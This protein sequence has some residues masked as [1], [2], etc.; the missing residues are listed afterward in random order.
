MAALRKLETEKAALEEKRKLQEAEF[1]LERLR[2][3]EALAAEK[4]AA[5]RELEE[6]KAK[7]ERELLRKQREAEEEK[8]R[9]Q[10]ELEL[11]KQRAENE[12]LRMELERLK[13]VETTP[14]SSVSLGNVSSSSKSTSSSGQTAASSSTSQSVYAAER[15]LPPPPPPQAPPQSPSR[16]RLADAVTRAMQN[17]PDRA[18]ALPRR[19]PTEAPRSVTNDMIRA[20]YVKALENYRDQLLQNFTENG[21]PMSERER[22][23]I[24]DAELQAAYKVVKNSPKAQSIMDTLKAEMRQ[25]EEELGEVFEATAF[26]SIVDRIMEAKQ[27][28]SMAIDAGV[29]TTVDDFD[30]EC[31]SF[32]ESLK[33]KRDPSLPQSKWEQ[34]ELRFKEDV[35]DVLLRRIKDR[36]ARPPPSTSRTGSAARISMPPPG[37]PPSGPAYYSGPSASRPPP[38]SFTPSQPSAYRFPSPPASSAAAVPT[39]YSVSASSSAAAPSSYVKDP[40]LC[41][42]PSCQNPKRTGLSYCSGSCERMHRQQQQQSRR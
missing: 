10:A 4:A 41:L 11:Q 39:P 15:V 6:Q 12:R 33:Q 21:K 36:S 17:V 18:I 30:A 13:R 1:E 16:I 40:R 23:A 8:V 24:R 14:K 35:H 32:L 22:L 20:A 19:K 37:P 25:A 28:L 3:S 2:R 5:L 42:R 29:V 26:Q 27:H 7:T 9:L 38:T 34:A 31:K